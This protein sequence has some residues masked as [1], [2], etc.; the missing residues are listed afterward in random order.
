[1]NQERRPPR[2]AERKEPARTS[3]RRDASMTSWFA[4]HAGGK[5]CRVKTNDVVAGQSINLALTRVSDLRGRIG[6]GVRR[7]TGGAD[8]AGSAG[9]AGGAGGRADADAAH[10]GGAG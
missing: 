6:P 7:M 9:G 2:P 1:M 10:S 8:D 4:L 3:G 5:G